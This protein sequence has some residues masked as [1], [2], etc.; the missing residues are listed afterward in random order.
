MFSP[1]YSEMRPQMQKKFRNAL[2]ICTQLLKD[3]N[4]YQKANAEN[5]NYINISLIIQGLKS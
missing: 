3:T 5:L 2:S 1:E 4:E